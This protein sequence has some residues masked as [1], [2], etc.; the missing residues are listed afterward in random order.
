MEGSLWPHIHVILSDLIR[1][2]RRFPSNGDHAHPGLYSHS[3]V[4]FWQLGKGSA[5]DQAAA[6]PAY[7]YIL[8]WGIAGNGVK[9]AHRFSYNLLSRAVAYSRGFRF[10]RPVGLQP[11]EVWLKVF[12]SGI[13]MYKTYPNVICFSNLI[14]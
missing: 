14:R 6:L 4:I 1:D 3:G 7:L 2:L 8:H 5:T 13:Q 11:G 12:F 9:P 10:H